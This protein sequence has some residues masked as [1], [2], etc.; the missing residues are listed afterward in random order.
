MRN[1]KQVYDASAQ[2]CYPIVNLDCI[3]DTE[4]IYDA[5][6][7][8]D[9]IVKALKDK[10]LTVSA[11]YVND[12]ID[13]NDVTIKKN[14]FEIDN[15]IKINDKDIV[16]YDKPL[17]IYK[18]NSKTF[19]LLDSSGIQV[20]HHNIKEPFGIAEYTNYRLESTD[21]SFGLLCNSDSSI[22]KFV[23]GI[24]SNG[25]SIK[26]Q[27]VDACYRY[28]IGMCTDFGP[29]DV[30]FKRKIKEGDISRDVSVFSISTITGPNI[31]QVSSYV[32]TFVHGILSIIPERTND[33]SISLHVD[34]SLGVTKGG[35]LDINYDASTKINIYSEYASG[36]KSS[37]IG[38]NY[39][40]STNIDIFSESNDIIKQSRIGLKYDA[41]TK[42]NMFA[43]GSPNG[44]YGS[45]YI[46][47]D[48][49]TKINMSSDI[50]INN[51]RRESSIGILSDAS[52]KINMNTCINGGNRESSIG[53]LSDAS[54][55]INMNTRINGGRRDSIIGI[56]S[57]A[58]TKIEMN[59]YSKID[60][61]T[62]GRSNLGVYYDTSTKTII[63]ASSY[64]S[65]IGINYDNST[66][67]DICSQRSGNPQ[68]YDH[69]SGLNIN[70]KPSKIAMTSMDINSNHTSKLEIMSDA[71]GYINILS[72]HSAG[73]PHRNSI[74]SVGALLNI[75][76]AVQFN[77]AISTS[78]YTPDYN[79]YVGHGPYN[80]IDD[81]SLQGYNKINRNNVKLCI[82]RKHK[83]ENHYMKH[84]IIHNCASNVEFCMDSSNNHPLVKDHFYLVVLGNYVEN[85]FG[86]YVYTHN[87]I[88]HLD[89]Q[90]C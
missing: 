57:D 90:T 29:Y 81:A 48:D 25:K 65:R 52:T 39:D 67:I 62:N 4:G 55:K 47:S 46:D 83:S 54:T 37:H 66:N 73:E 41:S 76:G 22:G 71:S 63:S 15:I 33:T 16:S 84:F 75:N 49:S 44:R 12:G 68:A 87:L 3:T 5:S 23:S 78:V 20:G 86:R 88:L 21:K 61:P 27:N 30:F 89:F 34:R 14:F 9:V 74:T 7:G 2:K 56:L 50:N 31:S 26:I 43:L 11:L 60:E 6:S 17:K 70:A 82:F 64:S 18:T 53:I 40:N 51:G 10:E 13:G 72:E 28:P 79:D 19:S 24:Y 59:T 32:D 69:Q 36:L 38:I 58:S 45:L 77:N 35:Y 1:I 8:I 80:G 42:V 85:L